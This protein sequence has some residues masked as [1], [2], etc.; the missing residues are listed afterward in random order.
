MT[1][2]ALQHRI[3]LLTIA[4]ALLISILLGWYFSQARTQDVQNFLEQQASNIA[5]PLALASEQALAEQNTPLLNRLLDISHRK[6]SPLVKS[7]AIYTAD[8]RLV[9]TSNHH[10]TIDLLKYPAQ[11]GA[12]QYT[13]LQSLQDWLIIRT[14]IRQESSS[15]EASEVLGYLSVQLQRDS[16]KM[17]R[18]SSLLSSMV[19]VLLALMFS[20]IAGWLLSRYISRP[21]EA[22]SSL[23]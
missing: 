17:A 16:I 13:E 19:A 2:I 6:N 23:L 1:T 20:A 3:L 14:P 22:M 5:E 4:P 7:I 15:A 10:P 12:L 9:A 18:Q 11:Q 8:H 21:V